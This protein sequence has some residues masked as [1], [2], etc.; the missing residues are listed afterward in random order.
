MDD[1]VLVAAA[2]TLAGVSQETIRRW[3]PDGKVRSRPEG[4]L[5]ELIQK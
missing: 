5:L 3:A 2:A 1:F 4:N